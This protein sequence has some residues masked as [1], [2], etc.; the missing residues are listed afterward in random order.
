[1][2]KNYKV[3]LDKLNSF[4]EPVEDKAKDLTTTVSEIQDKGNC[5]AVTVVADDNDKA[6]NKV[7]EEV[8]NESEVLKMDIS[9]K[10]FSELVSTVKVIGQEV[11]NMKKQ[12]AEEKTE[13]EK[14]VEVP[15]SLLDE[16]RDALQEANDKMDEAVDDE[17]K[18][19]EEV[20][21]EPI[22]ESKNCSDDEVEEFSEKSLQEFA[23]KVTASI[24]DLAGRVDDLAKKQE[25]FV[26]EFSSNVGDVTADKTDVA[27]I[28]AETAENKD[29]PVIE[30]KGEE[31]ITDDTAAKTET[32]IVTETTIPAPAVNPAAPTV[33]PAANFSDRYKEM[34][35]LF[36]F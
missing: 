26:E 11:L 23:E 14:T 35:N 9:T 5:D 20:K 7:N 8:L 12:F 2:K 16:V 29:A 33:A 22:N 34:K 30:E 25:E 28:N 18:G 21:E 19:E 6:E 24:E 27:E 1:M 36:N 4:S 15:V 31:Q 17:P 3:L 32:K 10:D 13:D